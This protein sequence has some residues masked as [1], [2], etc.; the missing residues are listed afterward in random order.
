MKP[1]TFSKEEDPLEVEAWIKAIEAKFSAF[2]IPCS[3]ENKANF[4]ALQ[5]RG[6]ALM[7][8]DHFKTMQQGRA[9]TWNDF[10]QAFKSHHI[11]KGLMDR[12]MRELLA[13]R[14]GSDTMYCY[15]QKFNSLCQ[16][17]GH[18]VDTDAKKMER[19]RDGL[20]GK[21]YEQLNLLEPENFHELVN[22]AISQEDAMKK[23]HRD[24]KRPSGFAPSSGTNKKFRFVKKNVPN[25]SQQ[26]SIGR[27][28]MNPPQGKPSGN[29]QFSSAQQQAPKPNA[30]PRNIGDRRCFNCGQP[31]HY[32]SDCPKPKQ[33]KPNQ[34]N[35]GAGNKPAT[36]AKKP[37]V[38]VRQGKLNFT[39][40]SDIPEGASVLT[41]TFSINDIPVKILFD[42]G[43]THS[44][45]SEKLIGK[46]G[47]MGSHTNPAYKIITPGGQITSST[48]ICG[49]RLGL[50]SKIFPT[51]LIAISLEGMNVILGMD[52]MTQHKVVL[53]LS[54]RVVE[55]NSPTVGHTTL[56]LPFKDG[57]D[58]CAYVTIISHLDE[59][60]VVCEYPDVFP[61]ELPGM[62]LD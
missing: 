46:M 18:H 34:Q 22:K 25:P 13:L 59:I 48:L 35:Q 9:V 44:F 49:V 16:Y 4:A 38:Q 43:A 15:A 50:G 28:T 54:D 30:P 57:T 33:N 60:P 11:P 6:E 3:E 27:W 42:S 29:F 47:L 2:V 23:A 14:Q 51:N 24:K 58:S 32:I 26:S 7:W 55:I 8:W 56:Y 45:I 1:P 21:L 17:G 37:M 5:L 62:P 41:G 53:D 20:D 39:T 19:F 36:P 52:W 12:K 10:K 40:M 61:D 31:G